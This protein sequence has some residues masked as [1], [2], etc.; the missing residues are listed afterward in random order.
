VINMRKETRLTPEQVVETAVR[1]FGPSGMDL[2]IEDRGAGCA[3]FTGGG[4]YVSI[5]A[6]GG[7]EGTE[8]HLEAR[9]WEFQTRQ[10][11]AGL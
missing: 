11:A 9:E 6:C 1:F 5:T 4:G 3:R 2:K 10:F 8:V 7:A